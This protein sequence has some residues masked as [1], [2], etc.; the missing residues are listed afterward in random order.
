MR[1]AWVTGAS[2]FVGAYLV[3]C[4]GDR[5]WRVTTARVRAGRVL[6]P[7]LAGDVVFHLAGLTGKGDG[8]PSDF[9]AAN[10]ALTCD[11]YQCASRA[12]AKGFVFLSTAKVLGER[13]DAALSADAPRRPGSVYAHSK[14][15]AEVRLLAA[16]AHLRLP[17]AIVRPP[18]VYGPGVQGNMRLLLAGLYYGV[19]LPLATAAGQRSFVSVRNLADALAVVGLALTQGAD[20]RVWHVTD[21]RVIDVATLCNI[22]AAKLG[23]KAR[24]WPLPR[25]AID[26]IVRATAG[27]GVATIPASSVFD[28]FSLQDG[29]LRQELGWQQPQSFDA[30]LTETARW[31]VAK[32]REA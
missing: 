18:L 11:L 14:A 16:H 20:V 32:R 3:R 22:L 15:A 24:L 29:A 28:A 26:F 4:L 13:S 8:G 19:P 27:R 9:M 10:C 1:R 5:G 21:G 25:A 2:G 17:L 7:P 30:A 12:G 31:F 23:R 6:T